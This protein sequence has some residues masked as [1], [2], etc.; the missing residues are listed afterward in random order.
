MNL[1][2][3]LICAPRARGKCDRGERLCIA[4][5]DP[6]DADIADHDQLHFLKEICHMSTMGSNATIASILS[7]SC[8]DDKLQNAFRMEL[9][10]AVETFHT[11][12]GDIESFRESVGIVFLHRWCIPFEEV[13]RLMPL[14]D[15]ANLQYVTDF[16][17]KLQK[18]ELFYKL[19]MIMPLHHF[20]V[21]VVGQGG[22]NDLGNCNDRNQRLRLWEKEIDNELLST[23]LATFRPG[24]LGEKIL[25]SGSAM[26]YLLCHIV[27]LADEV[28]VQQVQENIVHLSMFLF[29]RFKEIMVGRGVSKQLHIADDFGFELDE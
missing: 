9:R 2:N 13:S 5:A 23:L 7:G 22:L 19:R 25:N 12:D 14:K 15:S 24:T 26:K 16:Q 6:V 17:N 21:F 18:C 28:Y 10:D 1:M 8:G 20:V 4:D 27:R 11:L 3:S 29:D